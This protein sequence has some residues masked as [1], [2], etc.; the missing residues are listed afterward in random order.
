[1]NFSSSIKKTYYFVTGVR[2]KLSTPS[3]PSLEE[4]KKRPLP[5]THLGDYSK[6]NKTKQNN[7]LCAQ[8]RK[9][10]TNEKATGQMGEKICKS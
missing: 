5:P 8:Q 1:M 7:T 4:G 6:E 10:S 3:L 9:L 2:H